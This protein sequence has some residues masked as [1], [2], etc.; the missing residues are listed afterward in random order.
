[1]PHTLMNVTMRQK[2]T[3]RYKISLPK[4]IAMNLQAAA[5][6]LEER[7]LIEHTQGDALLIAMESV[8]KVSRNNVKIIA[9]FYADS[10]EELV[11]VRLRRDVKDRVYQEAKLLNCTAKALVYAVSTIF[12]KA[13]LASFWKNNKDYYAVK[14]KF[15]EFR[16]TRQN[17]ILNLPSIKT[18]RFEHKKPTLIKDL[19][20]MRHYNYMEE[21]RSFMQQ[22]GG[23]DSWCNKNLTLPIHTYGIKD[24][25]G[26]AQD[27]DQEKDQNP[28]TEHMM[29]LWKR[30]RGYNI[31]IHGHGVSRGENA[32][33]LEVGSVHRLYDIYR[34]IDW[35]KLSTLQ[36]DVQ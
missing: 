3:E 11:H 12:M 21:F 24:N 23:I 15:P 22:Y 30:G 25:V 33:H 7:R 32:P 16:F 8:L 9:R 28:M 31:T 13:A 6:L 1:M 18:P 20:V 17:K 26:K 36:K 4:S 19:T 5:M 34:H 2:S 27:D 10:E 29:R 35:S 14:S